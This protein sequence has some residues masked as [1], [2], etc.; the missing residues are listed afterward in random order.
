MRSARSMWALAAAAAVAAAL[1]ACGGDEARPDYRIDMNSFRF[2][3]NAFEVVANRQ[4]T[5]PVRNQAEVVHN[6]S[7]PAIGAD[8]DYRP[9]Q[10]STLIFIAPEA[11]QFEFFCKYHRDRGMSGVVL[12][13]R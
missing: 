9:G 6:I 10:S 5:V 3:P 2:E 13:V 1:A 11:G 4:A 8:F 7:I 12:V